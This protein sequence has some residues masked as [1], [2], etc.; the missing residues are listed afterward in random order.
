M[1]AIVNYGR[2]QKGG[3]AGGPDPHG[4]AG[5]LIFAMFK[6]SVRPLLEIN[7]R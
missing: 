7:R 1:A 5:L 2:I 6:F 3:G 4:N